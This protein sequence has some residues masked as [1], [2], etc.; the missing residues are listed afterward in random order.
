M[1]HGL[2]WPRPRACSRSCAL[3]LSSGRA[4][5]AGR[6]AE[7]QPATEIR[8]SFSD[9]PSFSGSAPSSLSDPP[10]PLRWPPWLPAPSESR[11]SRTPYDLGATSASVTWS[12]LRWPPRFRLR[13]T[14]SRSS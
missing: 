8:R 11:S 3:P 7:C 14:G 12:R 5:P 9:P 10:K 13:S 2:R 4:L 1:S 6:R